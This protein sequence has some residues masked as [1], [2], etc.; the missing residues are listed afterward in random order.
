M[1]AGSASVEETPVHPNVKGRAEERTTLA[2]LFL[3]ARGNPDKR[4]SHLDAFF[5]AHPAKGVW[6]LVYDERN[7]QA[8]AYARALVRHHRAPAL[9]TERIDGP[10]FLFDVLSDR[11]ENEWRYRTRKSRPIFITP[12]A[13]A[14]TGAEFENFLVD[15][16]YWR[17]RDLR[18]TPLMPWRDGSHRTEGNR[19]GLRVSRDLTSHLDDQTYVL[20]SDAHALLH[21]VRGGIARGIATTPTVREAAQEL[22]AVAITLAHVRAD[23]AYTRYLLE[24]ARG[25]IRCQV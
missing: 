24:R 9:P 20:L 5:A 2:E 6:K 25:E 22:G 3:T 16:L 4:Q 14:R 10:G 12:V 19:T 17:A 13:Y 21:Q 23:D 11:R 8:D 18:G 7:V 1:Y 15:R